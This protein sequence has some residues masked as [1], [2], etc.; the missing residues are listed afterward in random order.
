MLYKFLPIGDYCGG[1]VGLINY[2]LFGGLLLLSFSIITIIDLVKLW[3]KK[4]KF[5]FIPLFIV[6]AIGILF[7]FQNGLKNKKFWTEKTLSGRIEIESTPKSG[8]LR[9]YENGTF[10]ATLYSADYSCTFQGK[11]ELTDNRLNLKREDLAELT[12]DVFTTEY[13][14]DKKNK[15]IKPIN[16]KFGLI[17]IME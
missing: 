4:Q 7:Y 11:Y 13:T 2:V 15:T 12:E 16:K 14:I 5:D 6:L 17:E 9:L 1:F 8:L 3:K 10:G